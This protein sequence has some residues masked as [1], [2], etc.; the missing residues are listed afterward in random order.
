MDTGLK[1]E[2]K[3]T[4]GKASSEE[5]RAEKRQRKRTRSKE[6]VAAA[7]EI[8][9]KRVKETTT[10]RAKV[11]SPSPRTKTTTARTTVET[12]TKRARSKKAKTTTTTTL[13]TTPVAPVAARITTT[14]SSADLPME[15]R[16]IDDGVEIFMDFDVG[17]R[18]EENT[19][20]A[21]PGAGVRMRVKPRRKG[22][23]DEKDVMRLNWKQGQKPRSSSAPTKLHNWR[24]EHPTIVCS[25]PLDCP[26]PIHELRPVY[27][28]GGQ[29]QRARPPDA[30]AVSVLPPAFN[31]K[32]TTVRAP[33]N[34]K[35]RYKPFMRKK[36]GVK[37]RRKNETL[38]A[39][40]KTKLPSVPGLFNVPV[41]VKPSDF[42]KVDTEEVIVVGV[43]VPTAT[44]GRPRLQER[45]TTSTAKGTTSTEATV[46]STVKAVNHFMFRKTT[47]KKTTTQS[48]DG[49]SHTTTNSD[50]GRR[51]RPPAG[52][53]GRRPTSSTSLSTSS[54]TTTAPFELIK[55]AEGG[56]KPQQRPL[57]MVKMKEMSLTELQKF[58]EMKGKGVKKML[59]KKV[60]PVKRPA[61][62]PATM[63]LT[64]GPTSWASTTSF[65][66][67]P[68]RTTN[69]PTQRKNA[70]KRR[71][72][73][74][75]QRYVS[76]PWLKVG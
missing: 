2:R 41:R 34:G 51:R 26:E 7:K 8:S 16:T 28:F 60:V 44:A 14:L 68:G 37:R 76:F 48:V 24:V 32:A 4:G 74:K 36:Y 27:H 39:A 29:Q 6:K 10:R 69:R 58:M 43:D 57:D 52:F 23:K 53:R 19:R 75:F 42:K 72:G 25:N 46:E 55:V 12:T 31:T 66:A 71:G 3:T 54:G 50:S 20:R 47:P 17:K 11:T 61:P 1:K 49:Q 30:T 64:P 70:H 65:P 59:K 45:P 21:K 18:N 62:L 33:V 38:V 56:A 5:D 67:V 73:A 40:T 63:A 35:R 15:H 9:T 13:S 22:A